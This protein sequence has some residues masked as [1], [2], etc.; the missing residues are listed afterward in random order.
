MTQCLPT[1]SSGV[2]NHSHRSCGSTHTHLKRCDPLQPF[3]AAAPHTFISRSTNLRVGGRLAPHPMQRP[4]RLTSGLIHRNPRG[5]GSSPIIAQSSSGI[6]VHRS[7]SQLRLNAQS[8][9]SL[10]PRRVPSRLRLNAQ[11]P[12]SET[13]R[14]TRAAAA[15]RTLIK[16]RRTRCIIDWPTHSFNQ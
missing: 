1:V 5:C 2:I 14:S 10:I 8:S 11:L 4:L 9:S 6:V 16:K 3:A 13:H 7:P 12:S 15:Q